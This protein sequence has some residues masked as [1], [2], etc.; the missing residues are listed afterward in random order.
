[1]KRNTPLTKLKKGFTLI[2][3]IAVLVLIGILAAVALPAYTDMSENA[4]K[5]AVDAAVAEL[6]GRESTHWGNVLLSEQGY[7]ADSLPTTMTLGDDFVWDTLPT[8]P[9]Q[10]LS[11]VT[12]NFQGEEFDLIRTGATNASPATWAIDE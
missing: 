11:G 6:N 8:T 5:R 4:K 1:M 2:E 10:A 9:A 3:V 7:Q 12:L